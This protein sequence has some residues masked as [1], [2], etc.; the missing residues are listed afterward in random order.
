MWYFDE[1]EASYKLISN[2]IVTLTESNP[3]R[4][5]EDAYIKSG[6]NKSFFI[7]LRLSANKLVNVFLV[8][9]VFPGNLL[10]IFSS[11]IRFLKHCNVAQAIKGHILNL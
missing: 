8:I 3:K 9:L 11:K 10:S 2:C 4:L 6:T 1:E 5:I 7:L